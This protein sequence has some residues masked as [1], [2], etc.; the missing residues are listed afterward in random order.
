[1]NHRGMKGVRENTERLDR[2]NHI[3]SRADDLHQKA[4]S[5]LRKK[6]IDHLC[7]L[8]ISQQNNWFI[9]QGKVD[10]QRTKSSIFQMVPKIEGH[11]WIVD[12]VQVGRPRRGIK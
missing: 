7:D 3:N 8:D 1:M 6:G 11:Q 9:I 12:K 2:R 10:S 4:R 5:M